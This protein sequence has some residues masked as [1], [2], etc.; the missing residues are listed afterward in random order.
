LCRDLELPREGDS[1]LSVKTFNKGGAK[2]SA[3]PE[4]E[5]S[6]SRLI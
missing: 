5:N 3:S 2:E 6:L 1:S 4:M